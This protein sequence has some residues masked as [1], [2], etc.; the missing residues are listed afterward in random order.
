MT[1][2]YPIVYMYLIFFIHSPMNVFG[3]QTPT[4][5]EGLIIFSLQYNFPEEALRKQR[6]H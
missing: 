3:F 1:Q 6:I 4:I 5:R 2:W